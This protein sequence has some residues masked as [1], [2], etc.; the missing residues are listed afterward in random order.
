MALEFDEINALQT[1]QS[2]ETRSVPF[3]Q[4]FGEMELTEE[5][6]EKAN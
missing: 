4:Y 5:E 2:S 3:E 6:K 1:T